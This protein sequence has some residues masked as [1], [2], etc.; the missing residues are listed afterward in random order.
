MEKYYYGSLI[1][2][3]AGWLSI[4]CWDESVVW[5]QWRPRWVAIS[6]TVTIE[7]RIDEM[8]LRKSDFVVILILR[9]LHT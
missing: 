6:E 1:R 4:L 3:I 9:D 7:Y 8:A 5:S 2:H